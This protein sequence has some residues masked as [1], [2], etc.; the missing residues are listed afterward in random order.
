M[1]LVFLHLWLR[2]KICLQN[3][4]FE[5]TDVGS[6]AD[7]VVFDKMSPDIALKLMND[8]WWGDSRIYIPYLVW[9]HPNVDIFPL[10]DA[11]KTHANPDN[12]CP[13]GIYNHSGQAPTSLDHL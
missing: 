10:S 2:N 13:M 9:G 3:N 12:I 7:S 1:Y 11:L 4:L 5:T 6:R 8:M